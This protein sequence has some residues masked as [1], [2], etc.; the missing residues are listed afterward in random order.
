MRCS[1][2]QASVELVGVLPLAVAL[3]LCAGQALAAGV[4]REAASQAAQAGAMALV[5][6]KDVVAGARRAAPG[7]ARGRMVVR[8]RGSTVSVVL[9][10]REFVPGAAGLLR[11]RATADAGALR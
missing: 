10:P 8:Q 1:R 4:A 2:G 5:Q 7:W 11:A 9:Q 6:D 3:A